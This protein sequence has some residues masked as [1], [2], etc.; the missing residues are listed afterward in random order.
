VKAPGAVYAGLPGYFVFSKVIAPLLGERYP[1]PADLTA[2]DEDSAERARLDWIRMST[3][4][5]RL[6]A[7]QLPCALFLLWFERYLRAFSGDAVLRLVAVAAT[8]LGTNLLAYTHMFA[9]HA[10]YAMVAF[11]A[12]ATIEQERLRSAGR[13]AATRCAQ[14]ALAGLLTSACVALEYQALPMAL[15]MML[16]FAWVFLRGPRW[17]ARAAAFAAGGAGV[18]LVV[19]WFQHCAYGNALTPGHKLLENTRFAAEHKSGFWGI[20]LPSLHAVRALAV[21]PGYGFFAMSPFMTLG[22]FAVSLT[23]RSSRAPM[24]VWTACMAAVFFV[25]A[26]FVEWRAGW[27]VG[28]RYLVV[29]APFFGLGALVTLERVAGMGGRTERRRAIVRAAAAGLA[30]ASVVSIGTVGILVDTLPDTI[31]RP[32]AQFFV[33]MLRSGF[34][35]HDVGEWLGSTSGVA[36]YVALGALL[37]VLPV[38]ALL[39][40]GHSAM[41]AGAFVVGAVVGL[42]PALSSPPD[43]SALFVLHPSTESFAAR[44]EPTPSRHES[45]SQATVVSVP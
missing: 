41:R 24:I 17:P 37:A 20:T 30:F 18:V 23:P 28:P 31:G 19:M 1:S 10:E 38:L 4:A 8:A 45:P 33:P 32:F 26:G 39:T 14:A 12:F 36:W 15:V 25:N 3:W 43:G 22:L 27:T 5:L 11:V 13:P 6:T 34:V 29:F 44:W 2:M 9:S 40:R 35:A 42:V 16:F 7:S 21:D